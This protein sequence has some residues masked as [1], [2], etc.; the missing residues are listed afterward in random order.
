LKPLHYD[1]IKFHPMTLYQLKVFATVAKFKSFTLAAE[2]LRV[3]QPSVTLIVQALQRELDTKLF[4]RL[5]NKIHLTPVG[6]ELLR[7]AEAIVTKAE[8]IKDKID[9]VKGLKKGK[10]SVGGSSI[11][12]ASFLP[13]AIHMYKKR[14]PGIEVTLSIQDSRGLGKDLLEGKLD[15]AILSLAT[16][17]PALVTELYREED[18]VVIASP[19]HPLA[20]KRSIP[21]K[22]LANEP[23][24]VPERD[25]RIRD[26]IEQIFLDRGLSFTPAFEVNLR[27]GSRDAIKGAVARGLGIGFTSRPYITS[28]VK[29]G[30]LK[31]LK[32]VDFNLKRTMYITVHKSKQQS[33][34]VQSFIIF[35]KQFKD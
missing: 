29:A 14:H 24:I 19:N 11:A 12:A 15:V 6:E 9:E 21:L 27:L 1:D 4:E 33:V 5:G 30:R 23:L 8:G 18:V 2:A 26:E 17:S 28:D 25:N 22:L 31:T 34:H 20:R 7:E 32:V 10:I 35:L 13:I 16:R 3:R